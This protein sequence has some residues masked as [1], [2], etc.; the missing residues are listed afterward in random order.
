MS[1]EPTQS[2]SPEPITDPRRL[3][4]YFESACKAPEH[5]RI[6]TEHEKFAFR[7]DDL[8]PLPY[9][10]ECSIHALLSR[11]QRFGW[12]PEYEQTNLIALH[13]S[14]AAITLEP[15][16]QVE[17]SGA[18]LQT[19]HETC[20]ETN[21]HL[22]QTKAAAEEIGA[23]LIGIGFQPKWRREDMPWMPKQRY[24]IMREYMPKKGALGHDM[25]L[26]TCTVQVNLDF[27]SEADMVRKFR[28]ALALQPVAT[29]LFANSPFT[30]GVSNGFMSYRSHVWLDTDQDRCGIPPFVF[31]DG[32][33]FERYARYALDVPM[34]FV[35][36]DGRYIDA[37][38]QSFRDFLG[39][40]LPALPGQRPTLKDWADHL[41]TLFP[42]VRMKGFLEM[43]GAD[44]GPWRELC[45]LPALWV[46][47]LYDSV[48]L[49]SAWEM[50]KDWSQE[51]REALR[52]EVPRRGLKARIRG[53]SAA[54]LA[55]EML[56]LAEAGLRRRGK[57]NAQ[58][59][60]E[61]RFL[62]VL[63][64]IAGAGRTCA[65]ELIER[66]ELRWNRRVDPLF[67]ECAY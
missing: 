31:E 37:S 33:G 23:G 17:L 3:I 66:Y 25:M 62:K 30:E 7:L 61:T 65:E 41:T 40:R 8:R 36:R 5:W 39:G 42:E 47:I 35:V 18:P 11:L 58:G 15:A 24:A 54:E 43:R 44:A 51:E 50:A 49:D 29:A 56:A 67:S 55:R 13:Q 1:T 14:G 59:Q 46:G 16:G 32:M 38:G 6:G 63:W 57:L 19:L 64:K 53:R 20:A 9:S 45:A 28:V 60:D 2:A 27:G 48:S 52:R 12:Q 34:Y 10:G 4:D 21:E 22:R 26:R